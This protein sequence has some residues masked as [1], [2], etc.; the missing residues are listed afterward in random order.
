MG[1]RKFHDTRIFQKALAHGVQ[2]GMGPFMP[3]PKRLPLPTAKMIGGEN[4]GQPGHK[5]TGQTSPPEISK[6]VE[7]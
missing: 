1:K 3:R 2:Q 5:R 6:G 7:S 4:N